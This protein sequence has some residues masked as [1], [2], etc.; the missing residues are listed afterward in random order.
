[1]EHEVPSMNSFKTI[2]SFR[3]NILELMNVVRILVDFYVLLLSFES[4]M[5]TK[6]HFISNEISTIVLGP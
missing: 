6:S 2:S 3:G 5:V 1:M 4:T